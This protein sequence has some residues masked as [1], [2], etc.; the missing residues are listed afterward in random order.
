MATDLDELQIVITS[1][2][3][4]ASEA[5]DKLVK[6]LENLNSALGNLDASKVT[7]FANAMGKLATIGVSTNTTSKAIKGFAKELAGSFDIKSKKGIDDITNSL[8]RLYEVNKA[9]E[10][11][12]DVGFEYDIAIKKAKEAVEANYK[13]KEAV[14]STTQSVKDYIDATNKAGTKVAM[15]DMA[16]EFGENFKEMSD[17]LGSA[18][19]NK[20]DSTKEGVM[21]LAAFLNEMNSQLGTQFDTDNVDKG[22]SQLVETLKEAKAEVLDFKK[23]SAQGLITDDDVLYKTLDFVEKIRDFYREQ[24]KYNATDGLNSII[25]FAQAMSNMQFPDMSGLADLAANIN[26]KNISSVAE[27]IAEVGSNASSATKEVENLSVILGEGFTMKDFPTEFTMKDVEPIKPVEFPPAIIEQ[28]EVVQEKLLPAI[29]STDDAIKELYANMSDT[30][31]VESAYD[32][33]YQKFIEIQL[34]SK[35]LVKSPLTFAEPHWDKEGNYHSA[36]ITA[37]QAIVDKSTGEEYFYKVEESAKKCLPAIVDVGETALAVI[38]PLE[39]MSDSVTTEIG[40]ALAKIQEYKKLI[41]GMESGRI[42]FDKAQ[43]D[44]AIKGYQEAT[45]YV[46]EYKEELLGL[47]KVKPPKVETPDT[48][49]IKKEAV[50]FAEI[51]ERLNQIS[52]GFEGLAQGFGSLADKGTEL[53]KKL[54]TPLKVASEEYVEKFQKMK[55][56]VADFQKDFGAHM[57]KVSEFWKRTM[58]TFTFMIVRKVFTAILKEIDNA[59]QSLA[60]YSNAMGTAFNTDLSNMVADF[61]YLG[62]S[63]VSVFAPLLNMVAPIIDALVSKIATLISYIG[64]LFAA[65][66]GGSSFTKAKKNVT[67]YAESLD[68]ASKSAKALTMGIDELN[69]LNDKGGGGSAKPYDG[70][71]DAWEQVEIPDSIKNLSQKIKDIFSA[72]FDPLKKAWDKTKK[73]IISGWRYMTGEMKKLLG[74]VW[75]DF[76]EVWQSDIMAHVFTNLLLI[77]GDLEFAIGNLVRNFRDAWEKGDKGFKILENIAKILDTITTHARNVSL[78]IASWTED[79]SFDPLLEAFGTLTAAADELA[80]FIGGVFEDVMENV[81]LKYIEFLIEDGLPHLQHTIAEVIESFDFDSLREKLQPLESSFEKLLENLDIGK[82]EAFGNLGKMFADFTESEEFDKFLK[83][84][85][86]LMD[87]IDA[88]TVEKV[89]TGIGKGIGNLADDLVK[90]VG[91]DTFNAFID[92]LADWFKSVSAD[93]IASGLEKIAKAIL[94]FKFAEFASEGMSGFFKFFGLLKGMKDLKI[95]GEGLG[96]VGTEGAAA[97]AG[98]TAAAGG[99]SAMA[100]PAALVASA[101]AAVALA[102]FSMTK[103]Y[104]GVTEL[105][106]RLTKEFDKVSKRVKAFAKAIG[107]DDK[108]DKLKESISNLGEKLGKLK[109]FWDIIISTVGWVASV[110]ISLLI[111]AIS[112]VIDTITNFID[113]LSSLFE[114]L[115][116]VGELLVGVFTLDGDKIKEGFNTILDGVSDFIS[117][118]EEAFSP[119][120][121]Q[122][123]LWEGIVTWAQEKKTEI[124]AWFG[125]L[126][127]TIAEKVSMIIESIIQFVEEL[128]G[129]LG[130]A[131]GYVIGT[132][133]SWGASVIDWIV[134]NVPIFI[135]NI[136]KFFEELPQKVLDWLVKTIASLIEWKNQFTTSV[137]T[138]VPKIISD[139]MSYFMEIPAKMAALAV[140]IVSGLIGGIGDAWDKLKGGVSDFCSGFLSGLR[141]G[142]K[143]HSPSK[144]TEDVGGDLFDGLLI[145]FT[146]NQTTTIKKFT[147]QF[148]HVFETELSPRKF[149]AIGQQIIQGIMQ[150]LV[151]S[152]DNVATAVNTIFIKITNGLK[153]TMQGMGT[154]ISTTLKSLTQTSIMP[155]FTTTTWQP[156]FNNLINGVFKPFISLFRTW[157]AKEAIEPWWKN[158]LITWFS[159]TKWNTEIFAPFAT[160]LKNHWTAFSTWWNTSMSNISKVV[161]TVFQEIVKTITESMTKATTSVNEACEK[162][163]KSFKSVL[164]NLKDVMKDLKD[165]DLGDGNLKVNVGKPSQYATGGFPTQGTLFYAGERG[166]EFVSNV[167]GRTG[168]VSNSEITGIADAVYAT[169]NNESELL[170]QL[171]AIG[172]A[173][174]SKDPVVFSDKELAMAVKRGNS[175]MGMSIIT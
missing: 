105:L 7:S 6:G 142:F 120:V 50:S 135:T 4:E 175:S 42:P 138:E 110:F 131:L 116:G 51:S 130:Y 132:L 106:D 2:S 147:S 57:K 79:V 158:D 88:E 129:K 19:K 140:D 12:V 168:V 172:Q 76:I 8:M 43:Y 157:F 66:G 71:E 114:V 171:V 46:K 101:I 41:S 159:D 25:G 30:S 59:T 3:N 169:G 34:A 33:L 13:Y 91:S 31:G 108:I 69:I 117:V 173:M 152:T 48:S 104:G 125:S 62:R 82:T 18:F 94:L 20:L 123:K 17:V 16:K 113:I 10:S 40:R 65:L 149:T 98:G 87:S 15:G 83:T 122:G 148:I 121:F 143:C 11:G 139:F 21:D 63:I 99:L 70:W 128:P 73:Y 54:L 56:A 64:M 164:E 45:K 137:K 58:R 1:N 167:N 47:N 77:V 72:L 96:L 92:K 49:E 133:A 111:P 74:S 136:V 163:S 103:S 146:K 67:N 153:N 60:M 115:G 23:A 127:E 75:D 61:Q 27:A 28:A 161:K 37:W 68:Q 39:K 119:E 160:L 107:L 84:I 14:D 118:F 141:D 112:V 55:G 95:I 26:S 36:D 102:L 165:M 126:K 166:A 93:D 52:E 154:M 80:D 53:F 124:G 90:F 145:P 151:S 162:M 155:F 29:I 89:L 134:T 85:E 81:V 174:L 78:Y 35:E 86:H 170:A 32:A 156:M 44:E 9:Q 97:G 100:A 144:E 22:F 150:P 38:Q 5:L 109:D 24:S